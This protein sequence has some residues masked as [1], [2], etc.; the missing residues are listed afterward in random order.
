M[1]VRSRRYTCCFWDRLSRSAL[2]G[3][4]QDARLLALHRQPDHRR[5]GR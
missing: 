5:T 2:L 3:T 4:Q 1:L